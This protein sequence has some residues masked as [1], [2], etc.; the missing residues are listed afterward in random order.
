MICT[1][2]PGRREIRR[3]T[4][5]ARLRLPHRFGVVPS[6][7]VVPMATGSRTSAERVARNEAAFREANE[8][9]QEKA[10]PG[11]WIVSCRSSV[12]AAR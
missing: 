12:R 10:R 2:A 4:L 1:G 9:I 11:R 3:S 6:G 8:A 5:T 7:K